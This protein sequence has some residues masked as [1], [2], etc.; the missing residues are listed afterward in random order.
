[1]SLKLGLMPN[2]PNSFLTYLLVQLGTE[3][4]DK[5]LEGFVAHVVQHEID[6]LDGLLFVD[7]AID[8]RSYMLADEYKK[9]KGYNFYKKY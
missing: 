1:M 6:H 3:E 4:H 9:L 5:T 2:C 7:R 8:T